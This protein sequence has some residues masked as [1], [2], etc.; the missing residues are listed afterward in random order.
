MAL[1]DTL[2]GCANVEG[3]DVP[4]SLANYYKCIED[5]CTTEYMA[6]IDQPADTAGGSGSGGGATTG[7]DSCPSNGSMVVRARG[8][9]VYDIKGVHS[10]GAISHDNGVTWTAF[11]DVAKA[12]GGLIQVFSY[13]EQGCTWYLP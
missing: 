13:L 4:G 2:T 7:I 11:R 12:Y 10:G 8:N 3:Y 5:F 9:Q 1:M 6:C